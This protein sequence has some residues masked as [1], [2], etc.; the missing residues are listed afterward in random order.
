MLENPLKCHVNPQQ[1]PGTLFQT[2]SSIKID[3][4]PSIYMESVTTSVHC[5][6]SIHRSQRIKNEGR[7]RWNR[8]NTREFSIALQTEKNLSLVLQPLSTLLSLMVRKLLVWSSSLAF[9]KSLL[10]CNGKAHIPTPQR[11][12]ILLVALA[13]CGCTV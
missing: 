5:A 1:P 2:I 9:M 3:S 10:D 13:S 11:G 8:K 4:D 7:K 6:M 12:G